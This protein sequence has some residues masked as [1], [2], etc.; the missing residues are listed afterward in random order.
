M[1][2]LSSF[3]PKKRLGQHFLKDLRIVKKMVELAKIESD[4]L[5]IEIGVGKGILTDELIKKGKY[6]LGYEIDTSLELILRKKYEN[7]NNLKIIFSDFLKRDLKSD[8]EIGIFNNIYLIAN[9]PYYITTPIIFK[10]IKEK[11][12]LKKMIIMVQKEVGERIIAFP[13]TRNYNSLTI[14]L[15]YLFEITKVMDVKKDSFQPKPKIDSVV[16]VFKKRPCKRSVINE[17]AF[18]R[19][20]KDAF[21]FKRKTLLNNLKDYDLNVIKTFLIKNNLNPFVRAEEIP[22]KLFIEMSNLLIKMENQF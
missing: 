18:F 8:I 2:K 21:Q 5:I 17:E 7:T 20:V 19:L 14:I 6:V 9:L 16:L 12:D 15:N 11:I 4:S 22:I 1:E 13:K 10:I 3:R